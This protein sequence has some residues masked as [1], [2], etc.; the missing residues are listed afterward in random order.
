MSKAKTPGTAMAIF[1]YSVSLFDDYSKISNS[2][3]HK[4]RI[5]ESRWE[6]LFHMVVLLGSLE[7]IARQS[8]MGK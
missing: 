5:A 7:V 3:S 1:N 4:T 8:S 6:T 2:P